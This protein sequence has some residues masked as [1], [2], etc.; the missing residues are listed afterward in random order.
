MAVS[1]NTF[2][3]V[4]A[5]VLG[6]ILLFIRPEK[7]E[8][9]DH[10]NEDI[11]EM[12]LRNFALYELDTNGLKNIML[13]KYGFQYKDRIEVEEIDYTDSTR[14]LRNNILADYGVYNNV[15]IITLE[16]NVRY[17]REDGMILTTD[18]AVIDQNKETVLTP[19]PFKIEQNSDNVVGD[20]LYYDRKAG[21]THAKRVTGYFTLK[22]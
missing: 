4:I 17:Y 3:V 15:D 9:T 1:A 19:G 10:S 2:F 22:D 8:L 14:S 18:E 16:G 21:T 7:I 6:S 13:G 12:E 20:K 5:L 11:A